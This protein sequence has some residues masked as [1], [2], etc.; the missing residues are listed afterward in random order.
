[1]PHTYI[2]KIM[3]LIFENIYALSLIRLPFVRKSHLIPLGYRAHTRIPFITY[4]VS[5]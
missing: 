5:I 4:W 2:A 1:M 3:T